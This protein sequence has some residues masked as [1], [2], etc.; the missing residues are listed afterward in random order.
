M[1]KLGAKVAFEL[2]ISRLRVDGSAVVAD[3]DD[4]RRRPTFGGCFATERETKWL[5]YT[6]IRNV[7]SLPLAANLETYFFPRK[8]FK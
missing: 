1:A 8:L 5:D 6:L 7:C 3:A 4:G 2:V